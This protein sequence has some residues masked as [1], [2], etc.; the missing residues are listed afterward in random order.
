MSTCY[1]MVERRKD[2]LRNRALILDAAKNVF[3]RHGAA[4][5]LDL[6][7]EAAG[8][9]RATL[10]RNFEDRTALLLALFEGSMEA[11]E[12]AATSVSGRDDA[13]FALLR[14]S[15]DHMAQNAVLFEQIGVLSPDHAALRDSR[16]RFRRLVEKPL[17]DAKAAGLC[18]SDLTSGDIVTISAMIGGAIRIHEPGER[19]RAAERALSYLIDGLRSHCSSGAGSQ[20]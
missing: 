8:V 19:S 13:L 4:A 20:D 14:F 12:A 7:A 1:C 18:R 11:L 3:A 16:L 10:Y 2:S 9:G 15:G 17:A 5:P 6:V